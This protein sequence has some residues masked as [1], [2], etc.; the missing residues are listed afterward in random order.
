MRA[1]RSYWEEF[2]AG[3]SCAVVPQEPSAFA[4][5]VADRATPGATIVDVGTGTAR[6]ALWFAADGRT[7]HGLDYARSAVDRARGLVTESPRPATFDL[8]DL[9]DADAV[10][11]SATALRDE[12]G[13]HD[14]Y[15]R[16]LVHALED[17]GRHNLWRFA[18][19]VLADGGLLFLEFRTGKDATEPHL[20]GEHFRVFLPPDEVVDELE[21]SGAT[22]VWREE[23]HGLATFGAED[24]HV[25][26]LAASWSA[27]VRTEG[28]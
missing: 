10:A 14:V 2:Y 20:F 26:R 3:P 7:V 12:P 28:G 9:Y 11:T 16:F 1:E 8:L 19:T 22:V 15:G 25:C 23:G 27:N 5:W 4:R 18:G 21:R 24:P 17:T 13:V 6:D